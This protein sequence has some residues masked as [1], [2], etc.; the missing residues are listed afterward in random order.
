MTNNGFD[1]NSS[2][3]ICLNA[4][5]PRARPTRNTKSDYWICCDCCQGWFHASCGGY[6]V[7]QYAKIQKENIWIKCIVCCT[8]QIQNIDCE[9]GST[10]SNNLVEEA[11]RRRQQASAG[12]KKSKHKKSQGLDKNS[13]DRVS[14]P[15]P[16]SGKIQTDKGQVKT[17]SE[18]IEE[19]Y[20]KNHFKDC[21]QYLNSNAASESIG[22][23]VESQLESIVISRNTDIDKILVID[24]IN[25]AAHFSSTRRIL[26]EVHNFFPDIKIE[27]AYSL[28][29]GGVAIHTSCKSD[30]D[31]LLEELPSEAFG[32]GWK[33]PPKARSS[34]ILFIKGIDTSVDLS[35]VVQHLSNQNIE[36]LV[37]RRL[38]KRHTGKPTK[39]VKVE[40][41]DFSANLLLNTKLVVNN[42]V[43]WI[44]KERLVKVIRCFNCQSLG[45]LAKHCTR[46]R[47]CE[48]CSESHGAEE[49]CRGVAQCFNCCGSHPSSS[50]H[51]PAF[52]TRY[53]DLAKQYT[54]HQDID[55]LS[56]SI[57]S[58]AKH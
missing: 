39:V 48:F 36:V 21:T 6:T 37:I 19:E 57:S 33:H 35:C 46:E 58:E 44:E 7:N 8:Q 16:L 23:Q 55:A 53:E 17:E 14:T 1:H 20:P 30:R 32:G 27:F 56:A 2:C 47:H 22:A 11:V 12:R 9:Q 26:K 29:R 4:E 31:R 38:V 10:S 45:H 54:K 34:K 28:S 13:V 24:N 49:K 18:V 41:S 5:Q 52:I 50:S 43:C 40:C 3:L 51:C 25:N 15:E 42:I